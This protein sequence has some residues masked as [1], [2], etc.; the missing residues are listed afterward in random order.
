VLSPSA[1]V[2]SHASAKAGNVAQRCATL[3]CR[4]A[5]AYTVDL[6]TRGNW[7]SGN[8]LQPTG[9][10]MSE[11]SIDALPATAPRRR[12]ESWKEIAAYLQR[13]VRTVQLWEKDEH[14]PVHRLQGTVLAWTDE[15]D[16]WVRDRSVPPVATPS[17]GDRPK[18]GRS[19]FVLAAT[20][21]I[22]L[23]LAAWM[24]LGR[25][26][27]AKT[28]PFAPRDAVLIAAV[29]NRTEEPVFDGSI[30]Y[31]LD[32]E[33]SASTF[34]NVV[35]SERIGDALLL[36][37]RGP[38]KL[39][40]TLAREVAVRDGNVRAVIA[41]RIEKIGRG[42]VIGAD[43]IDVRSGQRMAAFTRKASGHDQVRRAVED[44]A[45]DLRKVAGEPHLSSAPPEA[46]EKVTTRSLRAA[47][48]FTEADRLIGFGDSVTAERLLREAISE[49]PEFASAYMHLAFAIHNQ[50]REPDEFLV[51]AEKAAARAKNTTLQERLFILGSVAAMRGD[52][53][54]ALT[55]YQNLL[56]I[57]PDHYWANNNVAG[58]LGRGRRSPESVPYRVK[59]VALR[60][61]QF[62]TNYFAA[63][64]IQYWTERPEEAEP[65]YRRAAEL[66][67]ATTWTQHPAAATRVRLR[68]AERAWREGHLDVL[69]TE[70]DAAAA[71]ARRNS[72]PGADA[73]AASV[74]EIE[75]ALGRT[76]R[77]AM[78]VR[79]IEDPALR[80]MV[81][82]RAAWWSGDRAKARQEFGNV[83]G[84]QPR[85]LSSADLFLMVRAGLGKDV[86]RRIEAVPPTPDRAALR[87]AMAIEQGNDAAASELLWHAAQ[88][89]FHALGPPLARLHLM[90]LDVI[91]GMLE[92]NGESHRAIELIERTTPHRVRASMAKAEWMH[93]QRRL[94]YIYR[95][96]GLT[97]EAEQVEARVA[98]LTLT[99]P[100]GLDR[101]VGAER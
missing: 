15:L 20:A 80:S 74:A 78:M 54:E 38:E 69:L 90:A 89:N 31:L 45:A 98:G 2:D 28:V 21:L 25:K 42:Y 4:T 13:S 41:T 57:N 71:Q 36:M 46:L 65:Y 27:E 55:H 93:L 87:G 39:D 32:R 81:A 56:K 60:P 50:R 40:R 73:L 34:V 3:A 86:Q 100:S 61:N 35:S 75:M 30:E 33:L 18:A 6:G 101:A 49:D 1:P 59:L 66:M 51:F 5:F 44:L 52:T 68:T 19:A 94:A 95:S 64:A 53:D 63:E 37:A 12:L 77:V 11:P 91:A 72:G 16:A 83:L 92:E 88:L 43:W 85:D 58:M 23:S 76:D 10:A 67:P 24:I 79:H 7:G 8:P 14:L 99:P 84:R 17:P 96:N 9:T 29:E 26:T 48:L 62:I 47:Q 70:L 22:L 82:G 97:R